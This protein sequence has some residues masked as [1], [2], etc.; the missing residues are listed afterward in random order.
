MGGPEKG[1]K[2]YVDVTPASTRE[3]DP[4]RYPQGRGAVYTPRPFPFRALQTRL[5]LKLVGRG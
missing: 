1:A 3:A 5:E 4:S 2:G